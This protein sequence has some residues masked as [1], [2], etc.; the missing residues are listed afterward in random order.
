VEVAFPIFHQKQIK[1]IRAELD[2]YLNDNTQAWEL[3]A[4]GS[5]NRLT[6][7]HRQPRTAQQILLDKLGN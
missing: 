6:P 3:D 4:Q 2:T 7:K 5:Y 1:R